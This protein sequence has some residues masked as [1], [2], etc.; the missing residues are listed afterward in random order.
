MTPTG[1]WAALDRAV[2]ENLSAALALATRLTG[3]AELAEEIVAESLFRAARGWREFRGDA[4]PR[5]WL[6]RI[7]I[8]VH[9]DH[10]A[11]RRSYEPL[12]EEAHD[13]RAVEP[14]TE[15]MADD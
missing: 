3:G 10:L 14:A 15:A 11:R 2:R 1:D 6:F 7:V 8:N 12:P 4:S 5:S 13:A 9:R